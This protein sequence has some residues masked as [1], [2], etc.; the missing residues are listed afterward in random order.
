ML[1]DSFRLLVTLIPLE[2]DEGMDL[3]LLQHAG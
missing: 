1:V 3:M 2:L